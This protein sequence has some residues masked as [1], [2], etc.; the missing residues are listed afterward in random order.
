MEAIGSM[1]VGVFM[2]SSITGICIILG[3]LGAIFYKQKYGNSKVVLTLDVTNI[4]LGLIESV[5]LD[6]RLAD[7]KFSIY[8]DLLENNLDYIKE[9]L[10][11]DN[12]EDR[13]SSAMREII[14]YCELNK[15]IL[16]EEDIICIRN[17]LCLIYDVL[18]NYLS[19][20]DNGEKVSK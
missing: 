9:F 5:L 20:R 10:N 18:G 14:K 2:V 6:Y 8:F 11:N 7:D 3:I 1:D 4:V 13:V 15:L 19:F 12:K 16:D 17:I